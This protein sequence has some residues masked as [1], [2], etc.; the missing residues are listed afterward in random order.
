MISH[1]SGMLALY[2]V[3]WILPFLPM[4]SLA[5]ST[6]SLSLQSDDE[7]FAALM[8]AKSEEESNL[9]LRSH[10][11]L[12]SDKLWDRLIEEAKRSYDANDCTRS[13]LIYGIA[14]QS[15][16][17]MNDKVHLAKALNKIGFVHLVVGN[18]DRAREYCQQ[19]LKIAEAIKDQKLTASAHLTIGTVSLWQGDHKEALD[20]LQKSLLLF[21]ELNDSTYTADALVYI[22]Q[23]YSAIGNYA[24]AFNYYN[25]AMEIVKASNE[26]QRLE[27]LL[28]SIGTLYAEQGDYEKMSDYLDRSLQIAKEIN[29]RMGVATILVTKGIAYR[30][31][32]DF[33]KALKPLQE[34][35]TIAKELNLPGFT[36][37]PQTALGS[38]YRLQGK[39]ELASDHLSRSLITAEQVG[40]KPETSAILWH[41]GE[42]HNSKGDYLKAIEYSDRAASLAGQIDLPEI[43]YLALTEKG[44]AYLALN[45][46]DLARES[47][48][49]AISIIEELRSQVSGGEQDYQRFF[50][51]RVSPYQAMV[52]LLVGKNDPAQAL[53]YAERAKARVLLDV[54]RNGRINI[55][56]LMSQKEQLEEGRLYSELVSLNTQIQVE[57]MRQQQDDIRLEELEARLQRARHA[58]EEF[59]VA[60][61][62]SHPELKIKRGLLPPF[63]MEVV[64]ALIPDMRTS[65]L[66]YVV[67]NEQTFL[68]VLTRDSTKQIK[69]EVKS[70]MVK[71]G[72][73]ANLVENF[74]KLLAV[75]HPGFRQAGGQLYDL[76]VKPAE[77]ELR[78][79][80]TL[81]II[82]DGPLW[83]LP[84]QALQ[85]ADDK[86]L[87]EAYAMYYA[88][89]LQILREMRKKATDMRMYP[90]SENG[91]IA[92]LLSPRLFA[93][94]NPS[95][96]FEAIAQAHTLRDT[97]FVS[98]PETER[99]V[100][101]IGAEVY[102]SQF[103]TI[104]IGSAA[105]ED[106]V[107]AEMDKYRVLH[108]ATHGVLDNRSPLYSYLVLA[109]GKNSGEDGL[110]EAWELM[111]MN[112]KAEMVV[113][114]ACN[115]ARGKVSAGEGMIGMTWALFVA[116]VPTVVASQWEVPSETTTNLMV[117]FHRNVIEARNGKKLSKAEA[118][119][120]AALE[121]IKDPRYRMKP[122]YWGGFVVIGD[123][124]M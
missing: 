92:S 55:N 46:S 57:R 64:S 43:N 86:Y 117:A 91:R 35:L 116:G 89:S 42:L 41:L 103:S 13:L 52:K 56:K 20:H 79:K 53:A 60:L 106:L 17:V 94:G 70:I 39:Y 28:T 31:Q 112:L 82:P 87:L 99:E 111:E 113:L 62:A 76:L 6:N 80:T 96:G 45:Q 51:N 65:L 77:T 36:I 118:W 27:N 78:G 71:Q 3:L 81:C 121:M 47:L 93:I 12:I 4:L 48:Q 90:M 2:C 54:L 63:T 115:T 124:G 98:L 102:G 100:Q 123:G 23:V 50:Q 66:E 84:F 38:I 59:Q 8:A 19:S 73:L 97:N 5:Q 34:S 32:G 107:K 119:R 22:G 109:P 11:Q 33:E 83:N 67:T 29:D 14:K 7:L 24:Q 15:A 26:K 37:Y 68:F 120:K 75:N 88:P 58:Y 85:T 72:D 40:D 110:L 61:F 30:E 18:Y 122:F 9:L 95:A 114:S 10:R 1:K 101:T 105:R 74:Q 16:E 108:F 49:D 104:Q 69:I 21:K 25:Q 44:K